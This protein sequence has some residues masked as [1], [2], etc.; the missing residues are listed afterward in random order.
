MSQDKAMKVDI[1]QDAFTLA[2]KLLEAAIP[3]KIQKLEKSETD[4][5]KQNDLPP[6]KF[7]KLVA[8]IDL[9]HHDNIS[10]RQGIMLL[11]DA[12]THVQEHHP[13]IIVAGEDEE[14]AEVQLVAAKK[15]YLENIPYEEAKKFLKEAKK[16]AAA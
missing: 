6:A 3:A 7:Y 8:T 16:R 10:F 12:L 9:E 2:E 5:L 11:V 13:E 15:E 1:N 14:H 4:F